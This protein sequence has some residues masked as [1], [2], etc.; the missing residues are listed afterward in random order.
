MVQA[1]IIVTR[2][3][4]DNLILEMNDSREK[5]SHSKL[6]QYIGGDA[7]DRSSL[8]RYRIFVNVIYYMDLMRSCTLTNLKVTCILLPNQIWHFTFL[9]LSTEGWASSW[10]RRVGHHIFNSVIIKRR[11]LGQFLGEG[12]RS[13][14]FKPCHR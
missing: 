8:F 4:V 6:T 1:S 14:H 3:D 12:S 11:G 9:P 2:I 13:P 7:M 10:G 5:F